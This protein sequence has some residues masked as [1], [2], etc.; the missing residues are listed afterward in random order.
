[1]KLIRLRSRLLLTGAAAAVLACAFRKVS[2]LN[3]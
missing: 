3:G 2:T 1:M